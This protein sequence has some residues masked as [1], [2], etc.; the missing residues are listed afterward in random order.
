MKFITIYGALLEIQASNCNLSIAC[1]REILKKYVEII[2]EKRGES[3]MNKYN[4]E[5]IKKYLSLVFLGILGYLLRNMFFCS[6]NDFN[7]GVLGIGILLLLF[8]NIPL[9]R[10]QSFYKKII[11]FFLGYGGGYI[12]A[13]FIK[14]ISY[15]ED[16][17]Y[18]CI[19][20]GTVLIYLLIQYL[21]LFIQSENIDDYHWEDQNIFPERGADLTRIQQVLENPDTQSIGL[22]AEWGAGK[23]FL[24]QGLR[25][26]MARKCI[27]IN[28]DVLAFHMDDYLQYLVNEL[29][30]VLRR[31]GI[32]SDNSKEL[33]KIIES[34]KFKYF[35]FIWGKS[36]KSYVDTFSDFKKELL[37]LGKIIVIV[38]EDIDRIND[39]RY[40]K[41]ILYLSEK[42]TNSTDKQMNGSIKTIYQ[43]CAS[44][45]ERLGFDAAF[46]DKYID[47]RICLSPISLHNMILLMQKQF[48]PD[49]EKQ[50]TE[51]EINRLP[52]YL[53]MGRE[54][55]ISPDLEQKQSKRYFDSYITPR[56]V[57]NFLK[58]IN[59]YMQYFSENLLPEERNVIQAF[60][61]IEHFLPNVFERLK[62]QSLE[63]A[64]FF[65]NVSDPNL[66]WHY[67][68]LTRNDRA[69]FE[70]ESILDVELYPNNF[71]NYVAWR[72][73]GLD[74]IERHRINN[75]TSEGSNFYTYSTEHIVQ[76]NNL[77]YINIER[78][79]KFI[80]SA[81]QSSY[82]D[83]VYWANDL[84]NSV[85]N[86]GGTDFLFQN[87]M[88]R[89][90]QSN[91]DHGVETIQG[92]GTDIWPTI[93]HAFQ[94]ASSK[95]TSQE[96]GRNYHNLLQLMWRLEKNREFTAQ[97]L[98][99]LLALWEG[100][101]DKDIYQE[102][103]Q[104]VMALHI[105]G[106]FNHYVNFGIFVQRSI[107]Q[108][109]YLHYIRYDVWNTC[110]GWISD[111]DTLQDMQIPYQNFLNGILES[112][113]GLIQVLEYNSY[114]DQNLIG[115][116][117]SLR[118]YI[119]YLLNVVQND[120]EADIQHNNHIEYELTNNNDIL[121]QYISISDEQLF[122]ESINRAVK[123]S[124]LDPLQYIECIRRREEYHRQGNER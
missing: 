113:D 63:E 82:N 19:C 103:I 68:R 67:C 83:Y 31:Y 10:N 73:L 89:M 5:E 44:N 61:F 79:I 16:R 86:E 121:S 4:Y 81:N 107:Y 22:E 104:N 74:S 65:Q 64:L 25:E 72:I 100:I 111:S 80:F 21:M 51:D 11:F 71:Q 56:R 45:M 97:I 47:R 49:K 115:Q 59:V 9:C 91:S 99:R 12:G 70:W 78:K 18:I 53:Y 30:A 112:I 2:Q 123:N 43:Y 96:R 17:T 6:K 88:N 95:W 101:V 90:R 27:F 32:Y 60:S 42:M 122:Y 46:L 109:V 62:K 50:L 3:L 110:N 14:E 15:I 8:I 23:T 35:T 7:A 94:L 13:I 76:Q 119:Q 58:D 85:L 66:K 26:K 39:P 87:W 20:L 36:D 77:D 108:A 57:R 105:N 116:Y 28:V 54:G 24:L 92:M 29:D 69:I 41:T 52:P 98:D 75:S 48:I 40:I 55:L 102:L 106:N 1:I 33:K 124:I 118:E 37:S 93:F 34:T 84:V 114:S 117:R 120:I 38:F